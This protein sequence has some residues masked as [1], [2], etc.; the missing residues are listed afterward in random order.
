MSIKKLKNITRKIKTPFYLYDCGLINRKYYDL[1]N[2]LPKETEIFYAIKANPDRR[3]VSLLGRLGA[4]AD[5]ASAGE[6]LIALKSG[7]KPN[8]IS[9][10]G[11]G[12]TEEELRLAIQK[13]IASIS[14]ENQGELRILDKLSRHTKRNVSISIRINPITGSSGSAIRMGGGSQQFGID[15][16]EVPQTIRLIHKSKYLN[17]IGLHMHAASQILSE[18]AIA[19]NIRYLADYC[20]KLQNELNIKVRI[21]N[22]GG[23]WG[24]PYHQGQRVL[25]LRL[26]CKTIKN[27]FAEDSAV[28]HFRNTRLIFEPGRFLV[29]EAGVYVTK[30]LY[31]K[32]SRGKIFLIVD[33][34][35]HQ[36]LAAAGLLGEGIKRNRIIGVINNKKYGREEITTIAGCLCTPLDILARD[37]KLP[38]CEEGDFL[39]I[40][41]S[42]AYSYSASPLM[43]LSHSL[44]KEIII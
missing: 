27:I 16:E 9:F 10:A 26:L 13:D 43:F 29:G 33:G 14:V 40:T 28:T 12:K 32:R 24:I 31:K 4:G 1:K 36:N 8:K 6:L 20:I 7:I 19:N 38:I 41:S 21:I 23:G 34:G 39:Y 15:E 3:I 2:Y 17:F 18:I 42:G 11:P 37:I 22:F 30:V 25:N 35:M 5:V 44:P